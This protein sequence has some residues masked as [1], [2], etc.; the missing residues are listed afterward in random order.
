M[1]LRP[2][3]AARPRSPRPSPDDV[4]QIVQGLRRIVKALH[5]YSQDVY[6]N[7]GLTGPQLWALKTL[8][9]AGPLS[10]GDLAVALAVHQSSVSIL[11]DRLEQR[12]L[13]R[14]RR[15][16]RDR[17]VVRIEL[18]RRGAAL[19]AVA[20]EP[21]QGR[22]LHGLRAMATRDVRQIRRSVERLVVAMEAGDTE[23]R[24]FFSDE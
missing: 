16:S 12:G 19:A 5:A 7:Y 22:L 3:P 10:T 17:R 9:R 18:T 23:A 8:R 2:L 13:V 11:L 20:P 1:Q 21:A 24:F 14:R 15:A 6:K 4:A